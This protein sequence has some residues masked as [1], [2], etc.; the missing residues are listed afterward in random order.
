MA[1]VIALACAY[2]GAIE[3][4]GA[5]P[6]RRATTLYN[7]VFA[8]LVAC[9]VEADRRTRSVHAHYEHAAFVFFLW[10]ITVPVYLFRTRQWRGLAIALG[11]LLLFEFPT[12]AAL[13]VYFCIAPPGA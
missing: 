5:E 6:S 12:L 2:M 10:P 4:L 1:A 13:L 7:F 11:V 3:Y 8:F 9:G